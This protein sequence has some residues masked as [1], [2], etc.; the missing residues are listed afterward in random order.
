MLSFN[1]QQWVWLRVR[2][3]G[4]VVDGVGEGVSVG[5]VD[6]VHAGVCMGVVEGVGVGEGMA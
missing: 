5:L 4:S 2:L 3:L 6:G 1:A